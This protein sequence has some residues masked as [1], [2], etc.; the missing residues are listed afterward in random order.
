MKLSDR[1]HTNC[2]RCNGFTP[3]LAPFQPPEV[4]CA[5]HAEWLVGRTLDT[6]DELG[7]AL[8]E[9]AMKAMQR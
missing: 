3:D 6:A 5:W 8:V 7:V 4:I 2:Y 1:T 9:L